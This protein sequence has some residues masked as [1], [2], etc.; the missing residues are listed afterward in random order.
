MSK[1]RRTAEKCDIYMITRRTTDMNVWTA[2]LEMTTL[3]V[4][5]VGQLID[6]TRI[7]YRVRVRDRIRTEELLV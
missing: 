4:M 7:W 1:L 5:E 3:M 2:V 6:F